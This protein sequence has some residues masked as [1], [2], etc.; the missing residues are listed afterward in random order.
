MAVLQLLGMKHSGKSTLGSLAA[1]KLGWTFL[2]L[3]TLLEAE[4]PGA[5]RKT[6]REIYRELGQATFQHYEAQAATRVALRLAS[7]SVVLAWGGGTA[8]NPTAV[9]ALG[10]Q[11]VLV[12]LD[13]K[14]EVLYERILRGGL[15]AFLSKDHPW[16]DFLRLYDERMALMSALTPHRLILGGAGIDRAL[17]QLLEILQGVLHAR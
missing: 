7:E 10:R 11:G 13:E 6:S 16:E 3:D 17:T 5:H 12:L 9:E 8:T 15:P 4:H 1:R 2:D 14:A